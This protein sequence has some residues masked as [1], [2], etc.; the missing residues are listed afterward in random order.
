MLCV[1]TVS[2]QLNHIM[3][4]TFHKWVWVGHAG[5]DP[6]Q[7]CENRLEA[8]I[9]MLKNRAASCYK[10]DE[11]DTR[12]MGIEIDLCLSLD[13][14]PFLWHDHDPWDKDARRRQR[15][16]DLCSPWKPFH[17][18][19]LEHS[20][21]RMSWKEAHRSLMYVPNS[22][23]TLSLTVQNLDEW[24]KGLKKDDLAWEALKKY[25]KVF[26]FDVKIPTRCIHR[27][28]R[29]V[30]EVEGVLNRHRLYACSFKRIYASFNEKVSSELMKE[31]ISRKEQSLTSVAL[32]DD[33]Q[34][35]ALARSGFNDGFVPTV[36][37]DPK[38]IDEPDRLF[39][40]Q[41]SERMLW[42]IEDGEK[43]LFPMMERL[44]MTKGLHGTTYVV[45]NNPVG[46]REVAF[47]NDE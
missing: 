29:M 10:N 2:L 15:G 14:V 3:N 16:L 35:H 33:V 36:R 38:L 9:Q 32:L 13:G 19:P 34:S 30:R 5:G 47:K 7:A 4:P 1:L 31:V 42:T 22:V 28:R 20:C 8:T 46:M 45:S 21:D 26:F 44:S 40:I 17:K 27:A 12:D 43:V 23:T 25:V 24:I 39:S 37:Y 6:R 11:S 41:A 18:G